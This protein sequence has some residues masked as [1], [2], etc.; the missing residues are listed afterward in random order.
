M[1]L[2]TVLGCAFPLMLMAS[3]TG[4]DDLATLLEEANRGVASAGLNLDYT[5]SVVSVLEHDQLFRLGVN[6]L[7]EA[8][9][10]IP[11][12]ETSISQFG[13]KK[14]IVRGLDNPN[15][16]TFDKT[17]LILDGV[18][19]ETAFLSN[20]AT[21]LELPVG[22]IERIEVLRGP[23]S[24]YFGSGAFNG[25][26]SV[27]TRHSAADG[28]GLFFGGGSYAYRMGGGRIFAPLGAETSLQA[29]VYLQRSDK[30]LYAGND[31][32]PDYIYDPGSGAVPFLRAS[33]SNERL[34]DYSIGMHLQHGGWSLKSRLKSRESGNYYGWNEHLELDTDPRNIER[35][36]LAEGGYEAPVGSATTLHTTLAYS[37]YDLDV[38]AQDYYHDP[39]AGVWVP[40]RFSVNESEDKFRVESRLKSGAVEGNAIEAGVL[41]QRI[42]ERS[43]EISDTIT[44]YGDRPVVEEGLRRDNLALYLRDSWDV[45]RKI[46]LLLAARGDYY[47]KEKRFYPSLQVGALYT[48]DDRWQFK[49]NYGHAFRVPSWVE[50]YSVEY[51]PGDGTRAGN[52]SL[53]AET[54]ETFEAIAIFK[55]DTSQRLQF[56]SYYALQRDVLDIDDKPAE[57]GYR[58]WPSRSSAGFEMAYDAM[59]L[60]QDHLNLSLSYTHTTYQTAGSG[61]EQLMPT[62]ALWMAKGYYV[63]Y[64]TPLFSLSL[65]AKY[66]GEHPYNREFEARA[67]S[68]NLSPYLTLDTTLAYVSPAHWSLMI[69]MK[70]LTDADVRYPSYYSRHP[71]GLPREGRNFLITAEYRF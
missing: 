68:S 44:P 65:L 10:I 39:D 3:G 38:E 17:R 31:F 22:I 62:A 46:G 59:L 32:V 52:P 67:G 15:T 41:W 42:Q 21:F 16:F 63:H 45:S 34:N 50:Q 58:N 56:N 27:T 28:S 40:Y 8:L 51:G 5:T 9:S 13:V 24:A 43:N 26:I 19:I 48:P 47:A 53:T 6:T 20:T 33:E 37:F 7:F 2:G 57:G 35:Y 36:F 55:Q 60:A 49:L 11:G 18:P 64:M 30:F 25:V 69:S 12:V 54:T 61:I 71:E 70:N 29:D 66:I 23:A 1:K 14:V 4:S